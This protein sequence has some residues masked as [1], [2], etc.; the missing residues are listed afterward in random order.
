MEPDSICKTC[1]KDFDECS[2]PRCGACGEPVAKGRDYCDECHPGGE[3][4]DE[5]VAAR[6]N[7]EAAK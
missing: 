1:G 7:R 2:C 3:A 6:L 4:T 5:E